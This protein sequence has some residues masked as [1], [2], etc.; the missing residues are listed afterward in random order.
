MQLRLTATSATETEIRRLLA[1]LRKLIAPGADEMQPIR[2]EIHAGFAVNFDTESAAGAPWA[3][4]AESTVAER[5]ALGYP[6]D[7]PILVRSGQYAES[8]INQ[9]HA[10]HGS[11]I[12]GEQGI[13]YIAEGSNDPR[14]PALE[15]GAGRMPARPVAN[16]S[17]AAADGIAGA[18]E[19]VI[20][21]LLIGQESTE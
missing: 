4:L 18:V 12:E 1:G 2:D 5:I 9:D 7:H 19:R 8:W 20:A 11:E 16:L 3:P 6:G 15:Y 17:E 13:W 14:A 21:G 10:D